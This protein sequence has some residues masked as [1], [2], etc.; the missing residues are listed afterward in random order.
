MTPVPSRL[1]RIVALAAILAPSF[2]AFSQVV[3]NEVLYDPAD[4]TTRIE[5]IELHNAGVSSVDVSG[6]HLEDAVDFVFPAATTIPAGGFLCVAQ[7]PVAFLARFGFSPLGPWVGKLSNDGER[8]QVKNAS[9]VV[10]DEVNYGAGFPWPTSPRGGGQSMELINPSLDNSLGGSWRASGTTTAIA[11]LPRGSAGWRYR[12]TRSEPPATWKQA[13]FDD[14]SPAATEWAACTLPAG[15]ALS[16]QFTPAV[17]FGTTVGYGGNTGDKTRAYYFRK[18]FT[19]TQLTPLVL[20]IRRDDGAVVW[21][22]NDATP[23]VI[24]AENA[25]WVAP[26]SY[27]GPLAPNAV[28]GPGL[29]DYASF[30]IPASKLVVGEN[31]IA[32]EVHQSSVSSSD[33]LLDAELTIPGT[34]GG[35]PGAP[36]SVFSTNAPPQIRQV[37]HTPEQ[38][39][40]GVT[41]LITAK[42]TDPDG[43]AS[44]TLSYQLVNPGGYIRKTDAAYATTWTN[45]TMNDAGTNGDLLAGDGIFSVAMPA[46]LQTNRRLIR[47]RISASDPTASV[48][49]P[50]A[51]DDQPNFAYLVYN[52]VPAWQGAV[53]PG[54]AAPR[55][56]VTT[57][58]P[59]LLNSLQ[60]WQLIADATDHDNSLYNSTFNGVRYYG[61][62]VYEGK[63]YDHIQYHNRGLG[64]TYQSGKNKFALFF[65]RARDIRVRNNW[66]NYYDQAWNSFPVDAC[67]EPWAPVHR[68]MAGVDEAFTYRLYELAGMASLRTHYMHWRVIRSASESGATQYESDFW[69][70][71]M[72]LEPTEGNFLGERGLPDGNIYAIEGSA[73]DKKHQGATQPTTTADWTTFRDT[74]VAGGQTEQW[75][76]DNM[77]LNAF[78]T[79]F[80]VNRLCG[81]V[82]V[83]PGDNYRYYHRPTDNRW[84]II[85]YDLDMMALPAHHWGGTLA[86]G[87]FWAGA[88]S[89]SVLLSRHANLALEFRNRA[90]EMLDL[91]ASDASP[92]GGQI[93]QLID[94]YAQ[95]VNPTG[96]ALTWADADEAMW[97]NHPRT[98]GGHKNNA[99]RTPFADSRGV[100]GMPVTNWTRTLPDADGNGYGD[101]EGMMNYLTGFTTN[102]WAGGAWLRSNGVPAGYGYKYLEWESLYG[103]WGNVST[104]PTTA[105]LAFP[106]T[107]TLTYS[108]PLG[109]PANSLDFTSSGF[110]PATALNGGTGFSA[111]QWRL[112]EIYAPG[113]PGYVVGT[114]R[115]YEAETVWTSG[116]LPG[117]SATARVPLVNAEPGKTYRAR[118]RHKDAN[119]RWSHWSAPVQFIAGTP[120]VT[121]FQQS[122]VVSELNYNPAPVTPAEFAAGFS[123]D[124][125]EWIE[126]KNVGPQAIDMTGA[127]FTKGVDFDFPAGFTI[128][129]GG[130]ALVVRNQAAFVSRWGS[131]FNSIIAGSFPTD[132]FSNG[133]ELVKLS[134]GAGTEILSFT[135]TDA[136]P[137]PTSPDGT[138]RTLNLRNP[139]AR[140][141]PDTAA[142]WKASY[143]ATGSP[144]ADDLLSFGLWAAGFPGIADP[145]ADSDGDGVNDGIE[146]ALFGNP[147]QPNSGILPTTARQTI[148]N[149]SYL[150][151]TFTKRTDTADLLYQ[152]QYSTDLATWNPTCVL[153]TSTPNPDGTVTETWRAPAPIT[154]GI[155]QFLR[156]RVL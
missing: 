136:A 145:A 47:Y 153:V 151:I 94:E 146:Y 5:Y 135:Y 36:N 4:V 143:A 149:D 117:F 99:F 100:G 142:N 131:S 33:L 56:T 58:P 65:N 96:A 115:R 140:P 12:E 49:V 92:S 81:N 50:Y 46:A 43:V 18:K 57:Y 7:D 98:T 95:M 2:H 69:G 20:N 141:A 111:M 45:L 119:G 6:W 103:G 22:N 139:N 102:T 134:Y 26:F 83:R 120:D 101:F 121:V 138:G 82:D 52:G 59:T 21:L 125:F 34:S 61:T 90:R 148:A 16:G 114:K 41:V 66:G 38:P 104:Q 130:F 62:L 147:T 73:G 64:S 8:I 79:F 44:A 154:G 74:A 152:P 93:G 133:S 127:R 80:A 51:D 67:A 15:F 128:P 42:I 13:S 28:T 124:D 71:Y 3:I 112:A 32:I 91:L 9:A 53:L 85:P 40:A 29:S 77:D 30:T 27:A 113:I 106:N 68:G 155:K 75:Y 31:V 72:G 132:N 84:V 23:T 129:P 105:D 63:V 60:T 156:L 14:S 118:V 24:S 11:I 137:W 35:S 37:T 110:T 89:Q 48:T 55:G 116:E 107:P 123:S 109:F 87:N 144:G 10:I 97:S 76:R 25:T 88:T 122:V 86:D 150:T 70:L 126:L 39:A 19:L 108:G 1:G 17:T 54:G 78:Y